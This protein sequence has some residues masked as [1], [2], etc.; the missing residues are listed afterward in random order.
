[1]PR[2][3]P[4]GYLSQHRL[5]SASLSREPA[6][7]AL[8]GPK[9][10]KNIFFLTNQPNLPALTVADLN[11]RRWQIETFF[12][13]IKQDLKIK[14]LYGTSENAIINEIWTAMIAY[15]LLF[16]LK[17][18]SRAGWSILKLTSLVQNL[19]AER[20]SLWVFLCPRTSDL[21]DYAQ[22]TLSI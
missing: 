7:G 1:M 19:L 18:R 2:C 3:W 8:R 13:W 20:C 9:R 21:P 14:V 11:Q 4:I 5:Q 22:L 10:L 15:L 17:L 12:P 6:P 16:Y